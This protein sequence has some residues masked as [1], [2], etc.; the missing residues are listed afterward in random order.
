MDLHSIGITRYEGEWAAHIFTLPGCTATGRS[1]DELL[2][3]LPLAIAEYSLW[4]RRHGEDPGSTD[5]FEVVERI[6]AAASGAADGEC[7]YRWDRE[8]A[9][10]D[11]VERAIR[12]M[13]Y[14]RAALLAAI[15]GIP[16]V[17]LDWRPPDSAMARIDPWKPHALTIREIFADVISAEAYYC[18]GV[19]GGDAALPGDAA[20][21]RAATIAHLRG[22]SGD[23]RQ[24]LYRVHRPWQDEGT[25][26]E[27][28]VRKVLRRI[29]GHERFHTQEIAQR[30]AWLIVG[31][32]DWRTPPPGA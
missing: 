21:E 14:V 27:W 30:L 22:V 28:T 16:P 11:E 25:H 29:I 19:S 26:E 15:E 3:L 17:I 9:E 13:G 23:A 32:P 10:A 8:R 2:A 4:M 31:V 24:A 6:D 12:I 18:G 5:A 7:C 20:S 1:E